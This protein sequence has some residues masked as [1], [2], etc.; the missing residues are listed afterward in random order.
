MKGQNLE[1][2]VFYPD[3]NLNADERKKL[4]FQ[5]NKIK[6]RW[7]LVNKND[8]NFYIMPSKKLQKLTIKKLKKELIIDNY[9][10]GL[11]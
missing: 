2:F 11:I 5:I 4:S 9:V 7:S 6:G 3:E 1:G 8:I 10:V